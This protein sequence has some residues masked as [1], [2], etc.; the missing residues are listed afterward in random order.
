[1]NEGLI[2]KRHNRHSYYVFLKQSFDLTCSGRFKNTLYERLV[3]FLLLI[4]FIN[5]FFTSIF[6]W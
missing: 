2:N 6:L 5:L 3:I 1:M 4:N